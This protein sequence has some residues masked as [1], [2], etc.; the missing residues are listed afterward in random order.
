MSCGDPTRPSGIDGAPAAK[1]FQ[2]TWPIPCCDGSHSTA[3]HQLVTCFLSGNGQGYRLV[4]VNRIRTAVVLGAV[5]LW[6]AA[7]ALACLLP[8]LAQT[9]AER[10]CCHHMPGHCGRS[11]MPVSHACCQAPIYPETVVV[12][13]QASPLKNA[14]SALPTTIGVQLPAVLA[15]SSR[16]LAFLETPPG[17]PLS[18]SASVLR[19]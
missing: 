7:P 3:L 18:R 10:A 8:G 13:E 6:A 14:I 19:I 16:C 17:Q 4:R 11:A 2:V 1:S 15:A 9:E 12:Q 5:L